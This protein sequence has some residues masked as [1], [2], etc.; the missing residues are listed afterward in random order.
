MP[1]A[2]RA[3]D[4]L[5]LLRGHAIQAL[6]VR[7]GVAVEG[8]L[9]IIVRAV[10]LVRE[11]CA[12]AAGHTA[13]RHSLASLRPACAHRAAAHASSSQRLGMARRAGRRAMPCE[14]QGSR[15]AWQ[16]A[17]SL[18]PVSG[19]ERRGGAQRRGAEAGRRGGGRPAAEAGGY[20]AGGSSRRAAPGSTATGVSSGFRGCTGARCIASKLSCAPAALLM[21]YVAG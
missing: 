12:R 16:Q 15:R 9:H 13:S 2:W 14:E 19:A 6:V 8:G 4:A 7:R 1:R 18:R 5:A 20:G 10:H 21:P 3:C 11:H 17:G